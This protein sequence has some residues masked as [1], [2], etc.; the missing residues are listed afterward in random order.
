ML[1]MAA[2]GQKGGKPLQIVVLGLSHVNLDRLKAGEPIVVNAAELGL[3]DTEIFIFSGR[4]E[5]TMAREVEE[6]IGPSTRTTIDPRLR[7]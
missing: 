6:L 7:D 5:M 3:P 1:K 2:K 4:D